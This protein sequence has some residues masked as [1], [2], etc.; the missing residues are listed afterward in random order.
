MKK[1][2]GGT[3]ILI[4]VFSFSGAQSPRE[5]P[6]VMSVQQMEAYLT[7]EPI[8]EALPAETFGYPNPERVLEL[9][10]KLTLTAEQKGQL[11]NLIKFTR[12]QAALFGKKIVGEELLLDEF[13]RKDRTDYAELANRIESIGNWY[14]RRRFVYLDAYR[15]T[16]TVLST[17]QLKKYHELRSLPPEG[18]GAE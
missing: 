2:A 17:E 13:F 15:K 5:V 10:P 12:G 6:S 18:A 4:L 14:W 16:R 3:L 9:E 8:T 1:L 11:Q 7:G